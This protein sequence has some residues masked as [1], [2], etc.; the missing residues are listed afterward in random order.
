[1]A[2]HTRRP[3]LFDEDEVR[4]ALR[5]QGQSQVNADAITSDMKLIVPLVLRELGTK[6]INQI[7]MAATTELGLAQS[8]FWPSLTPAIVEWATKELEE[9]KARKAKTD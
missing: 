8:A 7:I 5:R 9:Y 2:H 3:K 6:K 4:Y 1:M